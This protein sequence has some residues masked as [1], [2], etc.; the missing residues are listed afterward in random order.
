MGPLFSLLVMTL[1]A[2]TVIAI[3]FRLSALVWRKATFGSLVIVALIEAAG[4]LIGCAVAGIVQ[5][6]IWAG[7]TLT[8][9]SSVIAYLS[10]SAA[11]GCVAA[12]LAGRAYWKAIGTR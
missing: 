6:P 4:L 9:R 2:A 3:A 12:T 1:S 5:V 7:D 11:T 8:M 10:I